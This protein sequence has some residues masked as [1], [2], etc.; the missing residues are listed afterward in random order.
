MPTLTP[1][2]WIAGASAIV[3]LLALGVTIHS[4]YR[5]NR[6]SSVATFITLNEALRQG[7]QRFFNA[8]ESKKSD[9]FFELLN[10]LEITC[11]VHREKSIFGV[12]RKLSREYTEHCLLLIESNAGPRKLLEEAIHTPTTFENICWFRADMKKRNPRLGK[13]SSPT[14]G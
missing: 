11:G 7:W 6:N 12:S 5:N 9:E 10:L 14:D 13:F 2:D 3:A 8:P 1:S 4:I